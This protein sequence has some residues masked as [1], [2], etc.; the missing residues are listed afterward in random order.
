MTSV[1]GISAFCLHC[2]ASTTLLAAFSL[3]RAAGPMPHKY[4]HN[5][6]YTSWLQDRTPHISARGAQPICI[7][8]KVTPQKKG[9][10]RK[11]GEEGRRGGA[12]EGEGESGYMQT[13]LSSNMQEP[14]MLWHKSASELRQSERSPFDSKWARDGC[15]MLRGT[16]CYPAEN[17]GDWSVW[18]VTYSKNYK[19]TIEHA[20]WNL[21]MVSEGKNWDIW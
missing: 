5:L 9:R 2:R 10:E 3:P 6:S 11:R 1:I 19:V 20:T 17:R 21:W 18:H 8:I 14:A 12:G 4:K 13:R 16:L 7:H 15:Q